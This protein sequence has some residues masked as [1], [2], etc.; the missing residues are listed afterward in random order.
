MSE[1]EARQYG[2]S[3]KETPHAHNPVQ[4]SRDAR[5]EKTPGTMSGAQWLAERRKRIIPLPRRAFNRPAA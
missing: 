1:R 3:I 4:N 2:L 5:A